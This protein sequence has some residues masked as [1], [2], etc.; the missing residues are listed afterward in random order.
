M[1]PLAVEA[2][3]NQAL[4]LRCAFGLVWYVRQILSLLSSPPVLELVFATFLQFAVK[5]L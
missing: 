5:N 1:N 3:F 4:M 2:R